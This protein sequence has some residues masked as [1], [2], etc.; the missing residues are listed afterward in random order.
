MFGII[1]IWLQSDIMYCC[2]HLLVV[3][4]HHANRF[5]FTWLCL[6]RP[7]TRSQ[8]PRMPGFLKLLWSTCQ[9]ACVCLC[10]SVCP[11]PRPLIT[12]GVIWCDI[13]RVRL[14]KQVLQLFLAFVLHTALAIDKMDGHG[15]FNTARSECLPK[16]TK[17]MR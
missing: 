12:S 17:V 2:W 1:Y 4:L 13:D 11:P 7:G 8:R 16:K 3:Y 10:L 6:F 9:Y 14:V 5:Y 15:H